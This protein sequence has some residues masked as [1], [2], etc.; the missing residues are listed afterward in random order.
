MNNQTII[1]ELQA[2]M[3][4]A[5]DK[6]L[7]LS[8]QTLEGDPYQ[9]MTEMISYHLGWLET[10]P[11][12]GGKRLRPLLMLLCCEAAGGDWRLALP[13]ASCIELLHN[14]SLIHD[15]IQDESDLRRGR[16]TIWKRWGVAQAINIGDSLFVLARL[17]GQRLIETGVPSTSVLQILQI[18]DRECLNLTRGQY[19]D[20]DFQ[21]RQSVSEKEYMEMVS[22]KTC[23]MLRAATECGARVAGVKPHHVDRYRTFGH[24]LGLAFQIVDDILGI[25]GTVAITGKSNDTDLHT[26]KQS[27]PVILGMMHS[28]EF[29]EIWSSGGSSSSDLDSMRQA[30]VTS[31]VHEQVQTMAEEQ[32]ALALNALQETQPSGPAAIALEELTKRLS[33]R[34]Y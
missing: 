13:A 11:K 19:L 21:Q 31:G 34:T 5:I 33:R 23:A 20:L 2:A 26:R 27:L 29:A 24:H 9:T 8:V 1:A 16:P 6:D 25:W 12:A 30:L 7:H 22:G 32:G 18:I 28:K 10:T 4:D 17:A 3:L 15:D 14:F